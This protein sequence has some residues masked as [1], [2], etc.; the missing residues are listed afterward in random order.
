MQA[1]AARPGERQ[2]QALEQ[3]GCG[4]LV[5][6]RDRNAQVID[7]QQDVQRAAQL[8]DALEVGIGGRASRGLKHDGHGLRINRGV[9]RRQV[10]EGQRITQ[11]VV[12]H[13]D[14]LAGAAAAHRAP[15][16]GQ[17]HGKLTGVGI[18]AQQQGL[19]AG[20]GVAQLVEARRQVEH[21]ARLRG[22][23]YVYAQLSVTTH[24]HQPAC[25]PCQW[26]VDSAFAG[27]RAIS[28]FEHFR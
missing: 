4:N 8:F 22:L 7:D 11:R 2:A 23:S 9:Q 26:R 27:R 12:A 5:G 14:D 21:V 24:C 13:P 18:S 17:G 25:N 19:L 28:I 15:V 3:W 6:L 20:C 16:A 10:A 1:V